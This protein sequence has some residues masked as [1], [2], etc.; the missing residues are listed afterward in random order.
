MCW[1]PD[2]RE[3]TIRV[4]ST[5]WGLEEPSTNLEYKPADASSNP[6]LAFGGLIAAG[7]DGIDRGLELAEPMLVDPAGMPKKARAAMGALRYPTSSEEAL[8]R[9]A[10]DDVL[11]GALGDLL[12]TSYV[13][14]RRS[15]AEAHASLDEEARCRSHFVKY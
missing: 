8:D 6:Y 13:A 10:A 2:N 9:L 5:Y 7:L 11:T 12:T 4:P 1:G 15:E 14:V 3:A